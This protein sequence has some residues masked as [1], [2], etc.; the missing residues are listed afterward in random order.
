MV[1]SSKKK[2]QAEL[3]YRGGRGRGGTEWV[4]RKREGRYGRTHTV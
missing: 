2:K 1:H 3:A 4:E